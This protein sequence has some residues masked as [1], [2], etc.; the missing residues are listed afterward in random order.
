MP[1]TTYH[2]IFA[3]SL[4]PISNNGGITWSVIWHGRH[5]RFARPSRYADERITI[6]GLMWHAVDAL[7]HVHSPDTM[8]GINAI[9]FKVPLQ[10]KLHT[11]EPYE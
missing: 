10:R 9:A 1:V 4:S 8:N 3:F 7:R 6:Y 5:L 2:K 11:L